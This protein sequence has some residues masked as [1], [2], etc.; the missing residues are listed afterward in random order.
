VTV[1]RSVFGLALLA[2]ASFAQAGVDLAPFLR[3]DGFGDIALS[4]DGV[5]FATTVE[6]EDR[7]ALAIVRRADNETVNGVSLGEHVHVTDF[8]WVDE[9]RVLFAVARRFGVLQSPLATGEL[10]VA[11]TRVTRIKALAGM[12][13]NAPEDVNAA[14]SGA[15][16]A[17]REAVF[18]LHRLPKEADVVL[19]EVWPM[20][21][22][23]NTR[24]DRMNLDSR[25]RST[26]A[27]APLP[28]ARFAT[29]NAGHVRFAIGVGADNVSKLYHRAGDDAGWTLVNDEAASR[30]IEVPL[31]F[32]ADDV[33]AYLQVERPEGPDA[34]VA[35]NSRTGERRE[36]A[37]DARHD[38]ASV[39]RGPGLAAEPVGVL[40]DG[41]GLR[42][43]YFD[44]DSPGAT[45]YRKL[46]AGFGGEPVRIVSGSDDGKLAIVE[47]SSAHNPGDFFL[48]DAVAG[49]AERILSRREWILPAQSAEVVAVQLKA[50]DGLALDGLLTRPRGTTAPRPMVVMPHGGPFHVADEWRYDDDAQL[51]ARAGYAVLQVNF[52]GSGGRGRS[53]VQ[54]GAQEWGRAMQD[55]LT[56]ATKWAV[57]EGHAQ[58]GK[59]CLVGASYGAYA[60][61][62]GLAREPSLYACGVGVV[63]VYDL[64]RLVREHSRDNA[65]TALWSSDWVGARDALRPWSATTLAASIRA[66]VLLVAGGRDETAPIVHSKDMRDA[67]EKAGVKVDTLFVPSEGH[68]FF[69]EKYRREYYTRLLDFLATHLGGERAA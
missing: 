4:P 19:V 39:L 45:L 55:D 33:T 8:A 67:L 59:I 46:Q 44:P 57:A 68:G 12:G 10:Y 26:V 25:K 30:T 20:G 48:V 31:G 58:A 41:G 13:A 42:A 65:S 34:V 15:R 23:P 21:D 53:F 38:P 29:D 60:A 47:Q 40:F 28:R 61:M 66:P 49:K 36:V 62:V 54:A 14:S 1:L 56:D 5:H 69:A 6:R 7:T 17:G 16:F 11:D 43:T 64:E 32:A 18:L 51:L 52:R 24:V 35:W 37:R 2:S 3:R 27:T 22:L 50:R 9:H 63:G